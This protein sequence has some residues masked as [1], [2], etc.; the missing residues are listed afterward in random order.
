MKTKKKD[1]ITSSPPPPAAAGLVLDPALATGDAPG[2]EAESFEVTLELLDGLPVVEVRTRNVAPE[3]IRRASLD[4][5]ELLATPDIAARMAPLAPHFLPIGA[6]DQLARLGHAAEWIRLRR[7]DAEALSV[8]NAIGDAVLVEAEALRETMVAVVLHNAKSRPGVPEVIASI[9]AGKGY[10][11]LAD[12]L[13]R[14]A[15]LYVAHEDLVKNDGNHYD[16]GHPKRALEL[17]KSI[18]IGLQKGVTE[19]E[20][21]NDL[22]NRLFTAV[23]PRYERLYDAAWFVLHGDPRR[24]GLRSLHSYNAPKPGRPARPA[25]EAADAKKEAVEPKLAGGAEGT[26]PAAGAAP[27]ATTSP[28][29]GTGL[30]A[31]AVSPTTVTDGAT[32]PA[33]GPTGG[34]TPAETPAGDG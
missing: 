31:G 6:V 28:V 27:G 32:G 14:L 34:A 12:D 17:Q 19:S 9:T 13:E 15:K 22:A 23:V 10:E 20:R 21:W 26:P 3:A 33:D 24:D 4:L 2:V 11:D 25:D 1:S 8:P 5:A 18:R 7:L 30:G 29:A 16:P